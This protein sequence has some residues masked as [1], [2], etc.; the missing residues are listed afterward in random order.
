MANHSQEQARD[1]ASLPT[2]TLKKTTSSLLPAFEPLSSSPAL[3]RPLKRTREALEEQANYPTPVPTSSTHILSSSPTRA[4]AATSTAARP[5]SNQSERAPLASLP[6]IQ[7]PGDGQPVRLGRSSVSCDLQLSA[8]RAISRVHVLAWYRPSTTSMQRDRLFIKCVGWNPITVHAGG[9]MFDL[10][11]DQDFSTDVRDTDILIDVQGSRVRMHWP[12]KPQLGPNS[13]DEDLPSPSKRP[14]AMMRHSTPPSPSPVQTR[15]RPV[16][17]ISPSPAVQAI[18]PS[19][20]PLPAIHPT[21]DPRTTPPVDIYEDPEPQEEVAQPASTAD[22]S[23]AATHILTQTQNTSMKSLDSF[24]S[25]GAAYSDNDEENDPII[26]SFGPSGENLLPRL[27]SFSTGSPLAR[28]RV[29]KAAKSPLADATPRTDSP[30]QPK[31]SS[32]LQSV[33]DTGAFD[34]KDHVINQLAY[35]R[36]SSTPLSTI[37]G[38]LPRDAGYLTKSAL[39]VIVEDIPC[40]GEVIREGKDAAGKPLESEYYYIPEKDEDEKRKDAVVTDLMKPGLRSCRKQHKVSPDAFLDL[41][42]LT[43]IQQ[44]FWKKPK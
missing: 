18:L 6:S 10:R 3:P 39:Q 24:A 43:L 32:K 28:P 2:P 7:A 21:V 25:P 9:K 27:Q 17:P 4:N 13:S 5:V 44:Y 31:F 29:S 37:L 16:S 38:H 30:V 41:H 15:R 1:A 12:D 8:N 20:P 26:I 23:Q 33:I 19:S 14:R 35:S 11:K 34:I 22:P 36:L 42:T 40:V